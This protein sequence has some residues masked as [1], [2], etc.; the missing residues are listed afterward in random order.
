MRAVE[1]AS[2]LIATRKCLTKSNLRTRGSF[3]SQ[4]EGT[5]IV[6]GDGVAAGVQ[7]SWSQG[8]AARKSRERWMAVL[9]QFL[10]FIQSRIPAHSRGR[11]LVFMVV[12]WFFPPQ[13]GTKAAT[14]HEVTTSLQ[15][16]QR[17]GKLMS[18]TMG[19]D[20]ASSFTCLAVQDRVIPLLSV[21]ALSPTIHPPL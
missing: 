18:C 3:G 12:W 10:L 1:S 9:D 5:A 7:G 17:L 8:S 21:S 6:V 4:C 19:S 16:Q 2:F 15:L 14:W 13:W 11:A 20:P